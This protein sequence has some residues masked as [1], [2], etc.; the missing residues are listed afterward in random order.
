MDISDQIKVALIAS[1]VYIHGT[2]LY[3]NNCNHV[4]INTKVNS[5]ELES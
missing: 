5:P 2:V 1:N 4:Q 3:S